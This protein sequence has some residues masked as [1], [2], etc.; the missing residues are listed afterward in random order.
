[1][2]SNQEA[3]LFNIDDSVTFRISRLYSKFNNGLARLLDS[4]FQLLAREWR[5]LALLACHEPMSASELV[6]CS[7]M[8]KASVSRAAARLIELGYIKSLPDPLDGRVQRLR[9]TKRG[10]DVYNKIAP[11]SIKRQSRLLAGLA[12]AERTA[13]FDMLDR[14]ESAADALFGTAEKESG[15]ARKTRPVA[16]TPARQRV[17]AGHRGTPQRRKSTVDRP[18]RRNH[19]GDK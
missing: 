9:L 16:A 19:S 3:P 4:E 5:A 6:N 2:P 13:F 8:D 17:S 10:W 7:P 12:A 18:Q 1:M 15:E 11:H 14:I